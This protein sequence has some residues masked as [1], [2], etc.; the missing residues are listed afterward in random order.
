MTTTPAPTSRE[1]VER[2]VEQLIEP[3]GA[4]STPAP[5]E[6]AAQK[7]RRTTRSAPCFH[8]C[9]AESHSRSRKR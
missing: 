3:Y 4:N 2:L 6:L 5:S 9:V 8:V 1:A 7:A